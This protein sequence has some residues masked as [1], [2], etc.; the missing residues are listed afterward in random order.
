MPGHTASLVPAIRYSLAQHQAIGDSAQTRAGELTVAVWQTGGQQTDSTPGSKQRALGEFAKIRPQW[1][2]PHWTA[3]RNA[4]PESSVWASWIKKW[5]TSHLSADTKHLGLKYNLFIEALQNQKA[6]SLEISD[7]KKWAVAAV[8]DVAW[9]RKDGRPAITLLR[10]G[11][12]PSL[13]A[14]AARWM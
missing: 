6:E 14:V 12:A 5:V 1:G 4:Y 11:L 9:E 7:P 8:K 13:L 2:R 3:H 10:L